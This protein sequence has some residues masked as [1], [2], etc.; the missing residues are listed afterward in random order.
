VAES[1]SQEV[2]ID[3]KFALATARI[4]WHARKDQTLPLLFEPAVLTRIIY[5]TNAL[6]LVQVNAGGKRVHQILA[7][8][9][10][11]FDIELEY[12]LHVAK[13]DGESGFVLPT[14]YGLVNRLGL[15]I[16]TSTSMSPLRMPCP[17]SVTM[18]P[19]TR[20]W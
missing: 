15:R 16:L 19:R 11:F 1:V 17:S 9:E 13:K 4:R 8:E 6:K 18:P 3:E 20:R 2:Q 5:P 12:Q 7:Q 14:H 10:G